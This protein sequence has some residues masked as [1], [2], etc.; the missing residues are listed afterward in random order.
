MVSNINLVL[1][2]FEL[3][4]LFSVLSFCCRQVFFAECNASVVGA[5]SL[6]AMTIWLQSGRRSSAAV[7]V[8]MF[9]A[10]AH[11]EPTL[12]YFALETAQGFPDCD[13]SSI[14]NWLAK[15]VLSNSAWA[16]RDRNKLTCTA[17][18]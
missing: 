3:L 10:V 9:A 18:F 4:A 6:I 7:L 15:F 17:F 1:A 8:L 5:V 2:I 16:S 12:Q 11:F 14:H 13:V